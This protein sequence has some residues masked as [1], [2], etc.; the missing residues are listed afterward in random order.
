MLR[1]VSGVS[2]QDPDLGALALAR[3]FVHDI[4]LALGRRWRG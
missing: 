2:V 3:L 1:Q 4:R